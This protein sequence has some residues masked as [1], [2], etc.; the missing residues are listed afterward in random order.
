MSGC[1]RAAEFEAARDGRLPPEATRS[2]QQHAQSCLQ[3]RTAGAELEA[4]SRLARALPAA[5]PDQLAARRMRAR[6]V[7]SALL[8]DRPEPLGGWGLRVAFGALGALV[9]VGLGAFAR[10]H[11]A[12]RVAARPPPAE[13][14]R[15][16]APRPAEGEPRRVEL[17]GAGWLWPADDARVL[18]RSVGPDTRIDLWHGAITLEVRRRSAGQRFVVHLRDAEVEVRGTRFTVTAESGRLAR[19]DVVEGLVAVRHAGD[20]ERLLGPDAHLLLPARE[21]ETVETETVDTAEAPTA[22]PEP[23]AEVSP[24]PAPADP[25]VWFREGSFAY[26][27]GDHPSAVR[28]LERFLA[29]TPRRDPR[30]EDARYLHILSLQALDRVEALLRAAERYRVEFPRGV[31]RP[32]V[33]LVVAQSLASSGRCADAARVAL[34]LPDDAPATTRSALTR[35]LR[36]QDGAPP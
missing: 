15:P 1:P 36:C 28:A 19:V 25:G 2:L 12:P 4:L 24:R 21:T 17:G 13:A 20:P 34:T 6:V 35:V 26:A 31:R 11:N 10:H 8:G 27:R 18:V 23:P 22:P 3:C 14:P 33:V 16:S 5:A 32:E 30:R 29:A 7:G 9:L